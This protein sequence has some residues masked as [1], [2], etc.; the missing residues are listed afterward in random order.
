MSG[1]SGNQLVLFS[2]K[3]NQLFPSGSDIK[4]IICN[5]DGGPDSDDDDDF[6][7][8]VRIVQAMDL[9]LMLMKVTLMVIAIMVVVMVIL[10]T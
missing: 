2:Q 3:Q 9:I 5:D 8:R 1:P 7:D 6:S 10:M 4:C